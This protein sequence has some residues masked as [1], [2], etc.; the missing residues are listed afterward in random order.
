MVHLTNLK[1]FDH[2]MFSYGE[3]CPKSHQG[4]SFAIIWFLVGIILT[5]LMVSSITSS[6]SVTIIS[7][8]FH[9]ARGKVVSAKTM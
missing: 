7:D 3:R 6:L 2:F 9:V 4:K 5:S 8:N 1:A